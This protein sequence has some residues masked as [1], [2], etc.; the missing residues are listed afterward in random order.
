MQGII[1]Y[2]RLGGNFLMRL[3]SEFAVVR[4]G[5]AFEVQLLRPPSDSF[6]AILWQFVNAIG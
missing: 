3:G 1:R 4:L 2:M 6:N 5:Y